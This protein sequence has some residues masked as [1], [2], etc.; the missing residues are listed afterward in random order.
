MLMRDQDIESR[1]LPCQLFLQ[2][3]FFLSRSTLSHFLS[4]YVTNYVIFLTYVVNPWKAR[5]FKVFVEVAEDIASSHKVKE[6]RF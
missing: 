2:Q 5:I 6:L 4:H 1:T 3:A